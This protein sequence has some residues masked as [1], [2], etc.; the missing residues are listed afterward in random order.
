M[1]CLK[2]AKIRTFLI[3]KYENTHAILSIYGKIWIKESAYFCIFHAMLHIKTKKE[4]EI[5]MATLILMNPTPP[6]TIDN[7]LVK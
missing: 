3:R 6:S 2:Y 1:Y 7:T 5:V 4:R